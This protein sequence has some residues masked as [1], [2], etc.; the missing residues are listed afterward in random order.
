MTEEGKVW[1][2]ITGVAADGLKSRRLVSTNASPL[3]WERTF[4]GEAAVYLKGFESRVR[5]VLR[6]VLSGNKGFPTFVVN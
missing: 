6:N 1:V 3:Q 2:Q 5:C 4:P